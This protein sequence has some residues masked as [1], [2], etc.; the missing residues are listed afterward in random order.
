MF[1]MELHTAVGW[2][3]IGLIF[4]AYLLNSHNRLTYD[5]VRYHAMNITGAMLYGYDLFVRHTWEGVTL[6]F[7]WISI[8]ISGLVKIWR[9]RRNLASAT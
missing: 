5:D 4:L 6:E 3:G 8:A 9:K 2:V 1:G 7:I